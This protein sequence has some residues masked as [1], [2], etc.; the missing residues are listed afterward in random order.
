MRR[1]AQPWWRQA[2]ADL[3]AAEDSFATA[4]YEWSCFQA[5]QAAEKALK[6]FLWERTGQPPGK[7][8][9]LWDPGGGSLLEACQQLEPVF[10]TLLKEADL[11]TQHEIPS[12]YPDAITYQGNRAPVEYYQAQEAEACLGAA[13]TIMEFVRA[14]LT[15]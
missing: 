9:V 6:A 7:S 1:E 12:R 8:H 13:R 5:Q 14:F 3:R 11:L 4:H 2:E 10:A 15:P